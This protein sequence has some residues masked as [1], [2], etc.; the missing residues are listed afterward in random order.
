MT[1]HSRGDWGK[2]IADA[3]KDENS[4]KIGVYYANK[5]AVESSS[6]GSHKEL[7]YL[8]Q[9]GA[10]HSILDENSPVKAK[11]IEQKDSVQFNLRF[12]GSQ[13]VDKNSA[14]LLQQLST[15]AL[16]IC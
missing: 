11:R 13:V 4:G 6:K 7:H 12:K 5:T 2:R 1:V 16:F 15:P 3:V 14:P 9:D 10:M 8:E